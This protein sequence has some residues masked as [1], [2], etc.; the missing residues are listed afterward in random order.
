MSVESINSISSLNQSAYQTKAPSGK[1]EEASKEVK[2]SSE[3]SGVVYEKSD[4][5]QTSQTAKKTYTQNTALV[6][7]LKA[8]QEAQKQNLINIVNKM[9]NKQTGAYATSVFG[10]DSDDIWKF[11][12]SGDYTVDAETKAQAQADIAEGGYWSVGETSKRILD[13]ATALTGGDPDKLESMRDAF[14]KGYKQAEETWGGELPEISKQTY[15]AVLKGFDDL[16]SEYG[17]ENWSSV[18]ENT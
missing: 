17:L 13:F 3:N 8:D 4:D 12:A 16:A 14:L 11:L 18:S 7:Q 5:T 15:D 1:K 9:M 6:E 10:S 2:S